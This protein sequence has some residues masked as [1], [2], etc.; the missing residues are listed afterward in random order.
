MKL[1]P[2]TFNTTRRDITDIRHRWQIAV[3]LFNFSE[4]PWSIISFWITYWLHWISFT[5]WQCWQYWNSYINYNTFSLSSPTSSLLQ[6]IPWDSLGLNGY[7]GEQSTI[8]IGSSRAHTV[9]H[10]DAYGFNLVAQIQG[11]YVQFFPPIPVP[12]F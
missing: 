5:N 10:Q 2:W 8:W 6:A 3:M 1:T 4:M 7:N 11:R 12:S 9:C